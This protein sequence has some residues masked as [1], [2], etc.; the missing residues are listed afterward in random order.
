MKRFEI[1]FGVIKIPLDFLMTI[2]GFLVAYKLRLITQPVEGFFQPID[3]TVLPTVKEYLAFSIYAALALLVVFAVGNMYSLKRYM[4]LSKEIRNSLM[5]VFVWVALIIM[6]FFFARAFPFSRL[7]IIYSWGFTFLFIIFGRGIIRIIQRAILKLGIGKRRLIFVGNNRIASELFKELS[8]N[9]HFK[10]LGAIGNA[11]TKSKLPLLG[12]INQ[13]EYI[14][15]KSH[16]DEVIQTESNFTETQNEDILELCD[17]HHINYRFVPDLIDVRKTNINVEV[18]G[19]IPVISL[20]PTP[21]DGWGKVIKRATDILGS[22]IGLI[23]LSPI[24]LATA[25][26]IKIDSKGPVFFT[27]LD[28]GSPVKRIGKHGKPFKF[29]KFRSMH[30]DTDR[31]RYTK[32]A[33]NNTRK[34]GPL[35]KIKNDPRITSFGRFLRK[36]S[37]DELPQLWNVLKGD[38]SLVGPRPHLP[39]EVSKYKNFHRFVLTIKPGITGLAQI[40]GRSDLDFEQ[41]VKLDRYY[42]ENWSVLLDIKTIIKTLGVIF[43]EYEE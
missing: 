17:L 42:I 20:K 9:P 8:A 36:Y 38:L 35:I 31:L 21:L 28:D 6:Y 2:L 12:G 1:F 34:D 13:L 37:I 29:Y 41:E 3:F 11:N 43:R 14:L 24:F 15:K 30:P 18:M 22:A 40:N 32:L 7:A 10:I 5:L 39:E 33:E 4:S 16:V 19:S 26:S 23:I 25:I 27:K